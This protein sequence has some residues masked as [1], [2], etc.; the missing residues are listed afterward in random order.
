MLM[1]LTITHKLY[2]DFLLMSVAL[3]LTTQTAGRA[4][5]ALILLQPVAGRLQSASHDCGLW[6][7]AYSESF[8]LLIFQT[9]QT[10]DKSNT[11]F[12]SGIKGKG[13]L[14]LR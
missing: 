13:H 11:S 4:H 1:W 5:G 7:L 14:R 6:S 2:S 10:R 12:L 3:F 9:R 8:I